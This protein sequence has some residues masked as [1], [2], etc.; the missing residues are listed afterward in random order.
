ME[1]KKNREERR[2]RRKGFAF[3][4]SD[5]CPTNECGFPPYKQI[6]R[7]LGVDWDYDHLNIEAMI[8]FDPST[9]QHT[10]MSFVLNQI[11]AGARFSHGDRIS[12]RAGHW[13]DEYIIEFRESE[14]S[15]GPCLR[16][17]VLGIEEEFQSLPSDEAYALIATS[18]DRI[19]PMESYY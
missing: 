18:A 11:A 6:A 3:T 5:Y 16:A 10:V 4:I 7:S 14:D 17:V 9:G 2:K 12:Y 1:N 19:D 15:Y 8:N 13:N